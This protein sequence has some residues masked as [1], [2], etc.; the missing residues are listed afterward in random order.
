MNIATALGML[1][2]R[3]WESCTV[4]FFPSH[5]V[6]RD[7][8]PCTPCS[9]LVSCLPSLPDGA[10][11]RL[12]G[13]MLPLTSFLSIDAPKVIC[14]PTVGP[15]PFLSSCLS[16]PI[17]WQRVRWSSV[18]TLYFLVLLILTIPGH[19]FEPCSSTSL[20]RFQLELI[21]S[22]AYKMET[23]CTQCAY[24]THNTLC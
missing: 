10:T 7:S 9:L 8:L 18:G 4:F 5:L 16:P 21:L 11:V 1:G 17:V 24:Y 2:S 23:K 12:P 22:V 3:S 19:T 13:P 15:L 6:L 20:C 14:L